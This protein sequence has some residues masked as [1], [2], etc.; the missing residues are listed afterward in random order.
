MLAIAGGIILAAIV[1]HMWEIDSIL[2]FI[3][4]LIT[5]AFIGGMAVIGII[6]IILS[7]TS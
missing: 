3:R 6:A 5:A 7:S 4:A 2:D 1:L